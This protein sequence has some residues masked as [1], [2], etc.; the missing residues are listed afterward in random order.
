MW[1]CN[2][3]LLDDRGDEV[4]ALPFHEPLL[5][6][7]I[8]RQVTAS[9]GVKATLKETW[10]CTRLHWAAPHRSAH[11]D[12]AHRVHLDIPV[13]WLNE[14]YDELIAAVS[15][16]PTVTLTLEAVVDGETVTVFRTCPG[17][18]MRAEHR[19]PLPRGEVTRLR[20]SFASRDAEVTLNLIWIGLAKAEAAAAVR[21]PDYPVAWNRD[22]PMLVRPAGEWGEPRFARG[23]LMDADGLAELRRRARRPYGRM[24]YPALKARAQAMAEEIKARAS[25]PFISWSDGRYVRPFEQGRPMVQNDAIELGL[26]ALI[27]GDRELTHCAV[28]QLMMMLHCRHWCVSAEHRAVGSTWDQRCFSEEITVTAVALLADWFDDALT[29]AGRALVSQCLWDKGLAVI[30]R[31]MMKFEGLH[32]INQG[33]WFGRARVLGGLMLERAWPR[34]TG[35][36]DRAFTELHDDLS[37]YVESD[38]S[39]AEGIG[40]F[41][42]TM[43]MALPA[44]HAYAKARGR[45]VRDL[46]PPQMAHCEQYFA[47]LS[48]TRPGTLLLDG[49]NASDRPVGDA[50]AMLAGLYPGSAF[51]RS[52]MAGSNTDPTNYLQQYIT[53][54][55]TLGL[56]LGPDDAPPAETV[57]PTFGLLARSGHLT[58]F[59]RTD[60]GSMRVHLTGA[61]ARP[62]HSHPDK[63]AITLELDGEPTL[64]DRG[65]VRYQDVR[66]L[67]MRSSKAHNVLTP[68]DEGGEPRDQAFNPVPILAEGAGDAVSLRASIDLTACWPG[69][70]LRYIRR[71]ESES[72]RELRVVD[73]GERLTPGPVAFHLHAR[74]PFEIDGTKVRLGGSGPGLTIRFPWVTRI[75]TSQ[76]GIDH[77]YQP[78]HH[79][80]ATTDDVTGF[81]LTTTLERTNA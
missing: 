62:S 31:D 1:P 72:P 19:G 80:V 51:A 35:L 10:S 52:V 56:L 63:G 22:W 25:G 18:G 73:E 45:D 68:L 40:Y 36:V 33:P 48:G 17:Q 70:L 21:S 14:S 12:A 2:P 46:L 44:Y 7:Q 20:L 28:Q 67:G 3:L 23:L 49:D 9:A 75:S 37:S 78:V 16:P 81:S 11:G 41:L 8:E 76:D 61:P 42:L 34:A 43:H 15:A 29:D 50:V 69:V 77:R 57:I 38:G 4:I 60:A 59:R 32:H 74:R 6:R 24:V 58:S 13:R 47:V 79:L 64:I 71:L 54:A 26:V 65:V 55:G 39:V 27:E 5:A 53:T 66:L 30:E